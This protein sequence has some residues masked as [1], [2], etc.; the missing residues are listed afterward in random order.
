MSRPLS[1][2]LMSRA[3]RRGEWYSKASPRSP[4][5][6]PAFRTSPRVTRGVGFRALLLQECRQ[7]AVRGAAE[8]SDKRRRPLRT[9]TDAGHSDIYGSKWRKIEICPQLAVTFCC[10]LVSG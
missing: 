2:A 7:K 8:A 4:S 1:P 10:Q 6:K 5:R 3:T 9:S